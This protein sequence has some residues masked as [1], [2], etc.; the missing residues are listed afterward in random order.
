M[1]ENEVT[2]VLRRIEAGDS[3]AAEEL[4]PLVYRQ[5]RELAAAR[6]AKTPPGQTLQ[7]T[8]LVHEAFVRVIDQQDPRQWAGRRH[9]FFATARAMRDILVEQARRKASLKGG[10]GLRRRALKAE[11]IEIA[12][13]VEDVLEVDTALKRLEAE[14]AESAQLVML[15]YF[16]GLSVEQISQVLDVSAS[17]IKRRWRYVRAWFRRELNESDDG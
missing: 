11:P 14:D 17:T 1:E 5:L 6:M 4:L 9:F 12:V 15:R 16:A 8:A 13:P 3:R 2:L 7:P 10:G